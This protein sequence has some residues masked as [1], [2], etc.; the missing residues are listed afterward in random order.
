MGLK[1]LLTERL[2]PHHLWLAYLVWENLTLL[3]RLVLQTTLFCLS[4]CSRWHLTNLS[5]LSPVRKGWSPFF[6]WYKKVLVAGRE[7][8]AGIGRQIPAAETDLVV[9]LCERGIFPSSAGSCCFPC[10]QWYQNTVGRHVEIST[11]EKRQQM[12]FASHVHLVLT[13]SF[14]DT[15]TAFL[16]PLPSGASSLTS[17]SGLIV[18][19]DLVSGDGHIHCCTSA[20]LCA[21]F[22]GSLVIYL[23]YP[24]PF[25]RCPWT[26][27]PCHHWTL[28]AWPTALFSTLPSLWVKLIR[29]ICATNL[30]LSWAPILQWV[31]FPSCSAIY[32][33]LELFLIWNL[34]NASVSS[35]HPI[36]LQ[37]L[38]FHYPWPLFFDVLGPV[39]PRATSSLF[40]SVYLWSGSSSIDHHFV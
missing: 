24:M 2:S 19:I 7:G 26:H 8:S 31:S 32:S 35:P 25:C 14:K 28:D 34:N 20:S 13:K 3:Q 39:V 4:V 36:A 6:T 18:G 11:P 27:C 5:T 21:Y 15:T 9:C 10:W 33:H 40:V 29:K 12:A 16:V 37:V 38:C 23:P 17:Y 22:S 30:L 1:H